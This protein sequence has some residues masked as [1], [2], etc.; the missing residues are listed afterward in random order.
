MIKGNPGANRDISNAGI[1]E[2]SNALRDDISF[3]FRQCFGHF[4]YNHSCNG[5]DQRGACSAE[6]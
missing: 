6:A 1:T 4:P 5:C 3:V 2:T